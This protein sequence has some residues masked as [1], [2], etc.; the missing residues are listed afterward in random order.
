MISPMVTLSEAESL[1]DR[2]PRSRVKFVD[3]SKLAANI[4]APDWVIHRL[5]EAN[6]LGMIFGPSAG[7]KSFV[8]L[9][10]AC[11]VVTGKQWRDHD[12]V[13][14]GPVVYIS[15]E[16]QGGLNRRI[17]AWE[18]E[19][20]L[21]LPE[22][23]IHISESAANLSDPLEAADMEESI[24]EMCK[25]VNPPLIIIDTLARSMEGDENSSRDVGQVIRNIDKYLRCPFKAAVLIVHH[26]GHGSG[27]RARG[28]SAIRAALDFEIGLERGEGGTGRLFC[29]KA[30]EAEPFSDMGFK[31]QSVEITDRAGDRIVDRGTFLRSAVTV[32]AEFEQ[33][34]GTGP[35]KL[36]ANQ[37]K[38]LATLNDLFADHVMT[39][40]DGG[41]DTT[42]AW[43][44]LTD[45]RDATADLRSNR[46]TE[47]RDGLLA[48]GAVEISGAHCRPVQPK[49]KPL[50]KRFGSAQQ[51]DIVAA[52]NQ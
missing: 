3:G 42:D 27:E 16:G 1:P 45:W 15:G 51:M 13:R 14:K 39:L 46:F 18:I 52:M 49:P 36:G 44:K 43:V 24:R 25:G 41:R 4:K 9:D 26:T 47:A 12:I 8:T 2:V 34:S 40:S 50:G 38:A 21:I 33:G 30:K 23:S 11:C 17:R 22:D 31:L 10:W 37:A 19:N 7:G 35:K 5:M 6:S 28:S 48:A 29:G 32:D 20:K